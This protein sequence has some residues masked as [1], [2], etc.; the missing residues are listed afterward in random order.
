MSVQYETLL[1]AMNAPSAHSH[2]LL[3]VVWP[4]HSWHAVYVWDIM[5]LAIA[6]ITLPRLPRRRK[7]TCQLK[8][9]DV[10]HISPQGHRSAQGTWFVSLLLSLLFVLLYTFRVDSMFLC[11]TFS[12]NSCHVIMCNQ[13]QNTTRDFYNL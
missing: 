8:L 12:L 1:S 5:S 11:H 4:C 7:S 2:T 6:N 9:E 13:N 3:V 10:D